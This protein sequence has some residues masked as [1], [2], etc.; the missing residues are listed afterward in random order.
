MPTYLADIKKM[1][2][3]GLV[4]AERLRAL[5]CVEDLGSVLRAYLVAHDHL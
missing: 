5:S 1:N 4:M 3:L 2:S